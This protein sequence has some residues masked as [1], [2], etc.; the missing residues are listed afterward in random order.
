MSRVAPIAVVAAG[1]G[2]ALGCN[3][4]ALM[5][6]GPMIEV[7][8]SQYSFTAPGAGFE[9]TPQQLTVSGIGGPLVVNGI[10]ISYDGDAG[11]LAI[12]DGAGNDVDLAALAT[13]PLS[14][15]PLSLWVAPRAA[16]L[17]SGTYTATVYLSAMGMV[18]SP[19]RLR[20]SLAVPQP[21][22]ALSA[23]S[24][25]FVAETTLDPAQL[26]VTVANAGS[27]VLPIPTFDVQYPAT[28]GWLSVSVNGSTAPY[29]IAV[30]PIEAA[31]TTSGS[32]FARVTVHGWGVSNAPYF[33]VAAWVSPPSL[34]L[35]SRH[36]TLPLDIAGATRT[37]SVT[38][39]GL[40]GIEVFTPSA[41]IDY[42]GSGS[43]WLLADMVPLGG[44]PPWTVQLAPGPNAASALPS[45]FAI[46]HLSSGMS[47]SPSLRVDPW[48]GTGVALNASEF[49][50]EVEGLS[51]GVL[52]P[53]S[54]LVAEALDRPISTPSIWYT[55]PSWLHASIAGFAA[56][57]IV[58]VQP[59]ITGL[60]PGIYGGPVSLCCDSGY[61]PLA[62]DVRVQLDAWT[63]SDLALVDGHAGHTA[64]P[65]PD[66][67]I[68]VAG[69]DAYPVS[70][71][72][73]TGSEAYDPVRRRSFQV[74]PLNEPR[75]GHS[76]T[77]ALPD[78][79]VVIAGGLRPGT[80]D[81]ARTW[82]VYDP[83]TGIWR[84]HPLEG[85]GGVSGRTGQAAAA[86]PDGRVLLAGGGTANS[87]MSAGEIVDPTHGTSV[88]TGRM[89][90]GRRDASAA[91]LPDGRILVAGGRTITDLAYGA[92]LA[93]AEIFDPVTARWTTTGSMHQIRCF[94]AL[95]PLADGRLLA[96]GGS[97][98][99]A[100]VASAEIFD[101]A[102]GAWSLTGSLAVP[103]VAPAVRLPD[104]RVLIVGGLG[105]S[106][107]VERF[108][109]ATGAWTTSAPLDSQRLGHALA[110][111]PSGE[112]LVIG[113][114][115]DPTIVAG[116]GYRVDHGMG[117]LP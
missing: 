49:S 81:P 6:E 78:G 69:G 84:S 36:V 103:R 19:H 114:T 12:R 59:D 45:D 56:P 100:A 111:S 32:Y 67:T 30:R 13:T 62:L 57:W 5:T 90:E 93:S 20:V 72:Y 23:T 116:A 7:S 79:R 65:L 86:L 37:V 60:G 22:L 99:W 42:H 68:L 77:A 64:T 11:W 110:L 50:L 35:S 24:L 91:R 34:E 38:P 27:G 55:T 113:G 58:S 96:A 16:A 109:P 95:V 76:A 80:T 73:V 3:R 29:T 51:G 4:P 106:S 66:G 89:N 28:T 44:A 25:R 61:P 112:V 17:P 102:T 88:L 31:M 14:G 74:A 1:L 87:L 39:R 48:F 47:T 98:G 21:Q 97:D 63:R 101:P 82:E 26:S 108:D 53:R 15:S 18:N 10:S 105:G 71:G 46:V 52:A 43:D 41:F 94:F 104:G 115:D 117:V 40:S 33:D 9:P 75:T 70:A 92:A 83:V 8:A 107:T 2:L 85:D 54:F